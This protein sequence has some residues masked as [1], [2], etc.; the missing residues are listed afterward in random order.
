[1][2]QQEQNM[3]N[4]LLRRTVR[5]FISAIVCCLTLTARADEYIEAVGTGASEE[6]A[7]MQALRSAVQQSVGVF[8]DA[9]SIIIN[10]DILQE[11]I[12]DYSAGFVEDF[13]RL[14]ITN[15]NGIYEVTVKALVKTDKVQR[16]IREAIKTTKR[17]DGQK[18]FQS[19][20]T[21]LEKQQDA[22]SLL[23]DV[24]VEFPEK[25]VLLDISE[26]KVLRTF[27]D[28]TVEI[29]LNV[30]FSLAPEFIDRLKNVVQAVSPKCSPLSSLS[31]VMGDWNDLNGVKYTG[32]AFVEQ[33][34]SSFCLLPPTHY[35]TIIAG[36]LSGDDYV[37]FN[38]AQ[39]WRLNAECEGWQRPV[40]LAQPRLRINLIGTD[41]VVVI[42]KD[43]EAFGDLRWITDQRMSDFTGGHQWI[44][45]AEGLVRYVYFDTSN[46][47][48]GSEISECP[49][50]TID[51]SLIP[52][53]MASDRHGFTV[54]TIPPNGV[55]YPSEALL[56]INS[57][58]SK[59]RMYKWRIP[60]EALKQVESI[61]ASYVSPLKQLN[62][63]GLP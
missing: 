26:P 56:V 27:P 8:I 46:R 39:L 59:E 33:G 16:R 17:I 12:F 31:Q 50:K 37:W 11:E 44:F 24:A 5:V 53:V 14:S 7:I 2:A 25:A 36:M 30:T 54:S 47:G 62:E 28:E 57:D 4:Q 23:H 58:G 45:Y 42:S 1:M 22:R 20:S 60:L 40:W 32:V 15:R 38:S 41:D 13:K 35:W 3:T 52:G 51:L 19:A 48:P 55:K 63:L 21:M 29:G 61:E 49:E 10:D 43:F 34:G 9:E 6:K 18:V